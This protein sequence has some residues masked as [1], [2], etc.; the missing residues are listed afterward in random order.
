MQLRVSS[1][2]SCCT[3]YTINTDHSC[4]L[5]DVLSPIKNPHETNFNSWYVDLKRVVTRFIIQ[6]LNCN[7][8]RA[9]ATLRLPTYAWILN[10]SMIYRVDNIYLSTN[11]W[12]WNL[13][14]QNTVINYENKFLVSSLRLREDLSRPF[15]YAFMRRIRTR[16]VAEN[17]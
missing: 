12:Q 13:C 5:N 1:L 6:A 9:L 15:P 8:A 4:I 10:Y 17:R 11:K 3:Q 16:S 7:N 14:R 2:P